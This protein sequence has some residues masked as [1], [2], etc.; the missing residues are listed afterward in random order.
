MGSTTIGGSATAMS[1]NAKRVSKFPLSKSATITSVKIYIDGGGATSGS[2]PA[3]A[4]VYADSAGAPGARLATSSEVVITAGQAAGWVQFK[5]PTS[6]LLTAG[7][8]WLGL[9]SGGTS[10]VG[11]YSSSTVEGALRFQSNGTDTYVDGATDA[12]GLTSSD[13]KQISAHAIGT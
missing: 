2:E 4:I 1:V 9:H 13:N 12:F 6:V 3:R 8:Y 5:L 11:R 7:S 10:A